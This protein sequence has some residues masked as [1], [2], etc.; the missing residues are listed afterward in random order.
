MNVCIATIRNSKNTILK[1]RL[2]NHDK[3]HMVDV[4]ARSIG[5]R[6]Q[7]AG[8]RN[9]ALSNTGVVCLEGNIDDYPIIIANTNQ[10]DNAG[11]PVV[12]SVNNAKAILCNYDGRAV[13]APLELIKQKIHKFANA[14]LSQTGDIVIKST[15]NGAISNIEQSKPQEEVTTAKE[16]K[17]E[18]STAIKQV[19]SGKSLFDAVMQAEDTQLNIRS[20]T[21][22]DYKESMELSNRVFMSPTSLVNDIY[23]RGRSVSIEDKSAYSFNIVRSGDRVELVKY[24]GE[25][26]KGLVVIPDGV[27]HIDKSSFERCEAEEIQMPETDYIFR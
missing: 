25:G 24:I 11:S 7:A 5:N 27:T 10:V 26:Y 19:S 15:G 18:Q 14:E 17:P 13:E 2:Y 3:K 4:H 22:Q 21:A 9:L 16:Q 23:S 8:I 6:I 12:I 1:Y 20:F